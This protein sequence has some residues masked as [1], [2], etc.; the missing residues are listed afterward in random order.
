MGRIQKK[1][2]AVQK[3][4][5]QKK[6]MMK[7]QKSDDEGKAVSFKKSNKVLS[8]LKKQGKEVKGGTGGSIISN[9][10]VMNRWMQFLREVKVEFKKV[11]WPSRIQTAGSTVIIIILVI[12]VSFYLGLVDVIL[13]GLIRLVLH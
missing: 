3:Q 4:K 12:F 6:I 1:Q 10:S 5:K 2:T 8:V 9:D 13:S 7:Q 11:A